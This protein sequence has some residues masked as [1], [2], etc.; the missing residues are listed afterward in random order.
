MKEQKRRK[1]KTQKK[2]LETDI[3]LER[4]LIHPVALA[5]TAEQ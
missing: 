5:K 1:E 2:D 3:E 4:N